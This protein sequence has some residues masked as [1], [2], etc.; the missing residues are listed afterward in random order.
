MNALRLAQGGF[1]TVE[2]IDKTVRDGLGLRWSFMGPFETID[3]NAPEGL[4]DYAK[5]Y[6]PVLRFSDVS[7]LRHLATVLTLMPSSRLSAAVVA[8]D[9][10]IVALMACVVVAQP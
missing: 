3:L 2:D 9:R 6:G 5:R 7:R 10:C 4:A 8:C 1:A